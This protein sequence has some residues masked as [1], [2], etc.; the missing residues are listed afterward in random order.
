MAIDLSSHS[1][2][3]FSRRAMIA[4]LLMATAAGFAVARR[5]NR[6]LDYLGNRKLSDIIPKQIGRWTFVA[7]S[8]VVVPPQDQ[9]QATLY[10][11]LL[12]GLYSDG[13]Q[14]IML[15][16]AYG[17]NQTGFLQVHRPEFCYTAAGFKLSNPRE[18]AIE[19]APGASIRAK[20]LDAA[21][22]GVI[23]RLV[24]WTRIGNDM[25]LSWTEQKLTI[26]E[27]NLRRIIPDATLVR[28]STIVESEQLALTTVDDFVRSLIEAVPLP[29]RPI[30][31]A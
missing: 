24:Y 17:A 19:L 14:A 2:G 12:T 16:I 25:P 15:L 11:D 10:S 21:R 23:E 28:V 13:K 7:N 9:L 3:R 5:P 26:A 18:H 30:F 22:D 1:D 31:V 4:G 27:D 20:S 29:Q 6:P 8:G